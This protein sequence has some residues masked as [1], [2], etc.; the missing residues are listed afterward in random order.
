MPIRTLSTVTDLDVEAH[1]ATSG[2]TPALPLSL[3]IPFWLVRTMAGWCAVLGV[4]PALLVIGGTFAGIQFFWSNWVGFELVDIA[5]AVGSLAAGVVLLRFWKPRDEWRFDHDEALL[6]L[7]SQRGTARR[8]TARQV[9]CAWMP[10]ALLTATVLVWGPGVKCWMA[11]E[12]TLPVVVRP[13]VWSGNPRCPGCTWRSRRESA[14][15][16][17]EATDKDRE[18]AELDIVPVSSTGTAV[19]LA[20]VVSGLLLGVRPAAG[21][22][23]GPDGAAHGSG[24]CR[25]PV[26]AGPRVC[27]QVFGDGRRARPGVHADRPVALPDFRDAPGLAR[28]GAD[29]LRHVEQCAVREPSEDHRAEA[30]ARP[31]S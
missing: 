28:R 3:L 1:S 14:V 8:L 20:A 23:A 31:R 12:H 25:D 10:F 11:R 21:Q 30:R 2:R 15:T 29:R 27:D 18:K 4:W 9:A 24:H 5:A 16:G 17:H 26:H 22:D 19:F 7:R 6:Q 13:S